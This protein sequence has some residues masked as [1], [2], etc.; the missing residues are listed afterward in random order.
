[1]EFRDRWYVDDIGVDNGCCSTFCEA[2]LFLHLSHCICFHLLEGGRGY[3]V[4][5][6]VEVKTGNHE[7]PVDPQLELPSNGWASGNVSGLPVSQIE[8]GLSVYLSAI[9]YEGYK[10]EWF[11]G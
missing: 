1:M 11:Q 7:S 10:F 6:K 2:Q 5:S 3:G 9:I 8:G 4:D